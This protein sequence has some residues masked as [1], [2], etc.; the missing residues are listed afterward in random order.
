MN[1]TLRKIV[2]WAGI[3]LVLSFTVFMVLYFGTGNG[4]FLYPSLFSA[5]FGFLLYAL[6]WL[7]KRSR[8]NIE[9]NKKE[10]EQ[11]KPES[12]KPK[13]EAGENKDKASESNEKV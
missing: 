12:V 9:K 5:A 10:A 11:N 1:D 2:A 7:D 13:E 8:D 6:F 4:I 3:V